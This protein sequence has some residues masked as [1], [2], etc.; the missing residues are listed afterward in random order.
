MSFVSGLA[1]RLLGGLGPHAAF[2]V[3]AYAIAALVLGGLILWVA[4]DY[5][6]QRRLLDDLETRTRRR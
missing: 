1:E 3:A 5:R 6:V 2:I 4:L